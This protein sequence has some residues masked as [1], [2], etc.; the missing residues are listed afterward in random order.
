LSQLAAV[1]SL[2]LGFTE[3][4]VPLGNRMAHVRCSSRLPVSNKIEFGYL[5]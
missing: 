1:Y 5:N 4:V 2:L 3:A